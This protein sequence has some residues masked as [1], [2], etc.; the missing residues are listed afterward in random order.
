MWEVVP[1]IFYAKKRSLKIHK[2][3][4]EILAMYSFSNTINGLQAVRL[5]TL[6]KTDP[7]TGVSEPAIRNSSTK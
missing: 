4:R 6:L 5:G 2:I 3:H 1:R 7:D